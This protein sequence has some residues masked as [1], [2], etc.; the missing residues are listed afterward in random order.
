MKEYEARIDLIIDQ[1]CSKRPYR[2]SIEDKM[3]IEEQITK[4]LR[5]NLIEESYSPFAAPVTLAF[6]KDE[7]K[8]SRLCID[9]RDLNKNIIPQ[10]QPFPIIDDLIIKTR[11]CKYFTTLDIN[12][13]FWSIPLRIE[14]RRKT[15]FV[16]Q[17]GHFQW[18][19]LPFGLKTSPAIFQRI[20]KLGTKI[21]KETHKEWFHIGT[22]QMINKTCPYYT[23]K[24]LTKKIKRECKNCE[25]CIKNKS[26]GQK[27]Y[28][29]MS[30]LGPATKP[31]EIMSIDTIG[32]FGGQ[33]STK[34]YLHLIVDHFTRYA[35]I[36]TSKTQNATDFIKLTKNVLETDEIE[37]ILTDQYPGINSKEFKEFL[38]END[39]KLIFTAVNA[40]FSN[41]LNERLNQTLINKIR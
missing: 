20:L 33:R 30:H 12:S 23:T 27:K 39:V 29:L 10:A 26:R 7:N 15:A 18:T 37:T 6:K 3:E 17:E 19:C 31:F 35:F 2:C 1:Y 11:N 24:N 41:G 32:G 4:L 34:K 5:K 8:K 25:I 28:G 21:I 13:A 22:R 40:P 38:K 36:S 9:F 14:D 16:T